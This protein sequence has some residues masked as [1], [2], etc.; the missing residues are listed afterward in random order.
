MSC[1]K[2][3]L[4]FLFLIVLSTASYANGGSS[5]G[6]R[7]GLLF[8]KYGGDDDNK[9]QSFVGFH[10]G[11]FFDLSMSKGWYFEPGIG[12]AL[13]GSKLEYPKFFDIPTN[14]AVTNRSLYL[15]I[16]LLLRYDYYMKLRGLGIFAGPQFSLLLSNKTKFILNGENQTD[17]TFEKISKS[18]IS[19]IAGISFRFRND[20]FIRASYEMGF[21]NLDPDSNHDLYNRSFRFTVGYNIQ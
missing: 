6:F 10:V 11:G 15:D 16:P 20:L 21:I 7:G 14:G 5:K 17:N 13:K 2:I 1:K 12:I 19:L 18:D 3:L 4:P 9:A 8:S